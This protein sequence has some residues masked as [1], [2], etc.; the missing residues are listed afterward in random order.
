VA[1]ALL[2]AQTEN[3]GGNDVAQNATEA[4]LRVG[5][6][7]IDTSYGYGTQ[8]GIG[9]AWTASGIN[10]ESL[11]IT[12]K[13]DPTGYNEVLEQFKLIQQRLQTHYVDLLLV[14]WPG[15][16]Q[17]PKN[18]PRCKKGESTYKKCRQE[19]WKA[20]EAIFRNN[21][22]R[23]I[24]V[25]NF[26]VNHMEDIFEMGTSLIPSV[27]QVEFHVYWHQYA[28]LDFCT[29]NN[30]TFNSYSPLGAP[31]HMAF[32]TDRWGIPLLTHPNIVSIAHAHNKT[33][34][35]VMMRWALQQ[36]IVVNPR[37]K[38]EN[39]MRDNL[40]VFDFELTW[41]EMAQLSFLH[42]PTMYKVCDDPRIIP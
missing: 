42:H 31:D 30:I 13:V 39:H 14:H 29:K 36:N 8:A 24:G 26:E 25:S 34:A 7:R 19:S 32:N 2:M 40:N 35:Q 28:L 21:G 37:T 12:S 33:T 38:K 15:E 6:R 18:E 23:A 5:G 11:F 10:R 1:M 41:E 22:A 9:M 17:P 3:F 27:N 16:P 4:W 20:L